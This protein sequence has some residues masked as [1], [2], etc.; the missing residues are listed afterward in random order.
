MI[1]GIS[2]VGYCATKLVGTRRGIMATGLLGGLA[3]STAATVNFSRLARTG[4]GSENILVAGIL[5][6]CAT[7]FPRVLIISN[8]FSWTLAT[9]LVWPLVAMTV[10][11]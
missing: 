11:N 7:M 2:F 3:S 1:A 4:E 10:V 9:T 6:A 8:V 5:V